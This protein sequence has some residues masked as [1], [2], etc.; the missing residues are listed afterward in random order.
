M[1]EKSMSLKNI[2][3]AFMLIVIIV[4]TGNEIVHSAS[5]IE[6]AGYAVIGIIVS[7]LSIV[8]FGFNERRDRSRDK[9]TAL[10]QAQAGR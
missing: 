6:G 5:F 1:E 8:L 10:V 3:T 2:E 9:I 4:G 7:V